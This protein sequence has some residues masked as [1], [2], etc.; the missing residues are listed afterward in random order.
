[1]HN[2][3]A[4]KRK[5]NQESCTVQQ[6]QVQGILKVEPQDLHQDHHWKILHVAPRGPP[7][8]PQGMVIPLR[9]FMCALTTSNGDPN[10][11]LDPKTAWHS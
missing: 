9:A 2:Q 11:P 6:E 8:R 7:P 3:S 4:S 1:M 10:Y 5:E